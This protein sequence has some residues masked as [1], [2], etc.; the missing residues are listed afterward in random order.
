[1]HIG[2]QA[3]KY[4]ADILR[5]AIAEKSK[6][7]FPTIKDVPKQAVSMTV[8]QI[9]EC[10]RIVSCVPYPVKAKAIGNT[11]SQ[12]ENNM[13][14]ATIMRKHKNFVLFLDCDSASMAINIK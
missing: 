9:M 11:L 8:Y 7:C 2:E 1:M 4:I 14:P 13:V 5:N 3:T 12:E 10:G 6:V